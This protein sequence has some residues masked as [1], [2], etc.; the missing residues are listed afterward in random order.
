MTI[1]EERLQ[2]LI[3]RQDIEDCLNRFCRGMDR[4]DRSL[5]LSAFHDDATIAAGPYVGGPTQLYDWAMPL[6]QSGQSMTHH[7]LLNISCDIDGDQAHTE[8][9]YLFVGHNHDGSIWQAGGRYL[10]RLTKRR[11][12]WKIALRT[13]LIEWTMMAEGL[14]LPYAEVLDI[15]ANGAP[16]RD[17]SD[18]S[19]L[20]PL[21]NWR[22][23]NIPAA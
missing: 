16:A 11:G 22:A 5:F 6:H 20:R 7:N 10:D 8:T 21:R 15:F 14:P 18:P 9:Y 2:R 23:T 17:G 1:S 4:F 13:N 3:D 12:E 19:Y